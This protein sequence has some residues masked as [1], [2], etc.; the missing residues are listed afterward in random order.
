M[1]VRVCVCDVKITAMDTL[2]TCEYFSMSSA[3]T[4]MYMYIVS[5]Y[6]FIISHSFCKCRK[7]ERRGGKEGGKK[8]VGAP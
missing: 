3:C 8:G 2:C 5:L 1:C 7:G 4:Y 6:M